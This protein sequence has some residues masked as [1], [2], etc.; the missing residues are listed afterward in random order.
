METTEYTYLVAECHYNEIMSPAIY[1]DLA[2]AKKG[3]LGRYNWYLKNGYLPDEGNTESLKWIG[4]AESDEDFKETLDL[5]TPDG[6]R[7]I[8]LSILAL[9]E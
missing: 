3:L 9:E 5:T 2:S 1:H 4:E 8:T 7:K 6:E